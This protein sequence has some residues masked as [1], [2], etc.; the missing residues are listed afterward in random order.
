MM[1]ER[2]LEAY[3]RSWPMNL[4]NGPILVVAGLL[5]LWLLHRSR[6]DDLTPWCELAFCVLIGVGLTLL[7]FGLFLKPKPE[8]ANEQ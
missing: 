4:I 3:R 8:T 5:N 6:P 2:W 1:K 7:C